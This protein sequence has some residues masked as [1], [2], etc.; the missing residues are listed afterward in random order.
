M[1][2]R[3]ISVEAANKMLPLLTSIMSNVQETWLKILHTRALL[4]HVIQEKHQI[5]QTKKELKTT[6]NNLINRIDGYTKEV[7]ELGC[8]IEEF[9]RGIVN[10][11]TLYLGRKV[12]L[13]WRLGEDAVTH[14]HEL[15]ESYND[16]M[17]IWDVSNFLLRETEDGKAKT[18]S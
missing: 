17:P 15:D 7:E 10:F 18:N 2:T 13:T 4:E 1:R 3:L 5:G 6:L 9:R 11:P 8:F 14:W 16:R 12:F